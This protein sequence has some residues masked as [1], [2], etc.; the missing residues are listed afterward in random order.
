MI[1]DA[2]LQQELLRVTFELPADEYEQ[3]Q[4]LAQRRGIS[5]T[6]AIRQ[7]IQTEVFFDEQMEKGF[8]VILGGHGARAQ[9]AFG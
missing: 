3:L 1:M 4:R 6:K 9:L 2:A 7:A 8:K 5:V